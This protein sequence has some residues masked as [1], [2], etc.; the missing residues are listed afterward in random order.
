MK[1]LK[2]K[3]IWPK[4]NLDKESTTIQRFAI[5]NLHVP[6]SIHRE[7]DLPLISWNKGWSRSSPEGNI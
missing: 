3:P 1:T 5:S 4:E 7:F 6:S 2:N